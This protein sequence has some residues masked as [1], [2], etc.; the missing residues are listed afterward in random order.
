MRTRSLRHLLL[1]AAAVVLL[2]T[3]CSTVPSNT[4][5]SYEDT[6]PEG[7]GSDTEANF[8]QGCTAAGGDEDYCQCFYQ[9]VVEEV[10]FDEFQSADD[11]LAD[12]PEDVP[13][14]FE[15]FAEA[16]AG[17]G[18]VEGGGVEGGDTS[19]TAGG[20]TTT[21]PPATDG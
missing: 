1:T 12:D 4:P 16:C 10:P 21:A 5:E 11:A 17:G 8:M 19:T 3:G 2:A 14:E 15:E 9:R 18:N 6:T 13:P 7:T 20:D